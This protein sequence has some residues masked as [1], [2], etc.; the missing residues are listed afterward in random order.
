MGNQK[1]NLIIR[2]KIMV[3]PYTF[4]GKFLFVKDK[5][6][7]EWGF[8]S[9]GVKKYESYFQ[10]SCRELHEETSGL[11]SI[12]PINKTTQFIYANDYRPRE[13]LKQDI[14]RK[15]R[16]RSLYRIYMFPFNEK[17]VKFNY[18]KPNK[19]I[20]DIC[21]STYDNIPNKW[22]LCTMAYNFL[23]GN[24]KPVVFNV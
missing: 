17:D 23:F 1:N 14:M 6:T 12:I 24:Y 4:D 2:K 8:I 9:G 15:E 10:A 5:L 21:V 13:L 3:I 7:S 19:E 22:L 11:M 16:V 20:S 18:F